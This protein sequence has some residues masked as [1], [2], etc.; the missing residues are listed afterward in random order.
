MNNTK[1]FTLI[2]LLVVVLIIGILAAIAVPK[3][4]VAVMK[5]ELH[6]GIPIVSS[7]YQAQQAYLLSHGEFATNVDDLDI[8]IPHNASCTKEQTSSRSRYTCDF[9][10][11]GLVDSLSSVEYK[12]INNVIT[13]NYMLKDNNAS[14]VLF[15]KDTKWC[16]AKGT[17]KTA[18]DICES[19]G[20]QRQ[21]DFKS[22]GWNYY[23]LP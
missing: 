17:S 19:L 2:E 7:L 10:T 18:L 6:K 16:C 23:K 21:G 4:Q 3:Y 9:G 11:V 14:N 15:E 20:G 22:N 5:A 8:S 13:Y 1:A 12:D